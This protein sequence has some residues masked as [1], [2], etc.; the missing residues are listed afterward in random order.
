MKTPTKN[1]KRIWPSLI[2]AFFLTLSVFASVPFATETV[3]AAAVTTVSD[4][5]ALFAAVN[6]GGDVSLER[7]IRISKCLKIPKNVT[8]T[9]DLNGKMLDRGLTSCMDIGSVI[10]VEPFATLTIKDSSVKNYGV[11]TGGASWNGGGVCNHGTLTIEGGTIKGNK[12]QHDTYGR[13]AGIYTDS[14]QGS[15][16]SLTITGG[17]IETNE[18]RQGGGIYCGVSEM[19]IGSAV[20]LRNNS[21]VEGGAVYL[22]SNSNAKTEKNLFISCNKAS[23]RGAAFYAVKGSYLHA[24]LPTL[25]HNISPDPDEPNHHISE[26]C[27]TEDLTKFRVSLMK[28]MHDTV[29]TSWS[30]LRDDIESG[31][32]KNIILSQ[33]LT[34]SGSDKEITIGGTKRVTVDLNGFTLNR[35]MSKNADH[36][37]VFRVE[38]YS[39]LTIKDSGGNNGGTICGGNSVN[40]GG[41]CN[42]GTLIF[43]GGTVAGNR[44]SKD[45]GGILTR[46]YGGPHADLELSGGIVKDNNANYGGGLY[47]DGDCKAVI[48][49]AVFS[50]NSAGTDGGGIYGHDQSDLAVK[51]SA[52]ESNTAKYGA[53]LYFK[54]ASA[55]V[56]NCRIT[57]NSATGD[58]GALFNNDSSK[59]TVNDSEFSDNTSPSKAGAITNN[60]QSV[61]TLNNTVLRYNK[62]ATDGGAIYVHNS[63]DVVNMNGCTL[64]KNNAKWGAGLYILAGGRAFAFTT[65]FTDNSAAQTGGAVWMGDSDSSEALFT[66]CSFERNT[67]SAGGGAAYAQGRGQLVFNKCNIRDQKSESQGGAVYAGSKGNTKLGFVDTTVETNKATRGGGVYAEN[68]VISLRGAVLIRGNVSTE[69]TGNDVYLSAKSYLA[70]PALYKNAKICVYAAGETVAKEISQYQ[71]RYIVLEN[72]MTGMNFNPEK[73]VD[74]PLFATLFG[75]GK[76]VVVIVSAAAG[77]AAIAVSAL[78]IKRKRR[79]RDDKA[80]ENK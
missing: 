24:D 36:G 7:N 5:N 49:N 80:A 31:K 2:F 23:R 48:N 13:G 51:N 47:V 72:P 19:T 8:V 53:G 75:N 37:G 55:V 40:G 38:A 54:K 69:N 78:V 28:V 35:N 42:H 16:A 62:A 77:I 61:L 3:R 68:A 27:Y 10:R 20:V 66:S 12:A 71:T 32:N 50:G 73:T 56:T 70:S 39:Q 30:Q 74:T 1:R 22:D 67:A 63:A 44:A 41:I 58:T 9:L 4:E 18:A 57:G 33:D 11:I 21:A 17:V 59:C 52:V 29:Y 64:E 60:N 26:G 76:A 79:N 15:S 65:R 43:Q 34:A 25:F 46:I 14:Y 6:R 45:G